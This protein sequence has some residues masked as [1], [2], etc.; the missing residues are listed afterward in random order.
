MA[1]ACA[2]HSIFA[3]DLAAAEGQ[4]HRQPR[5]VHAI[6]RAPQA[7]AHRDDA[8]A[9][10]A[11]EQQSAFT[12]HWT[13]VVV[14]DQK[15][16]MGIGPHRL[17]AAGNIRRRP[18]QRKETGGQIRAT[19]QIHQALVGRDQLGHVF[20]EH[21][22]RFQIIRALGVAL[23]QKPLLVR[24]PVMLEQTPPLGSRLGFRYRFEAQAHLRD[25]YRILKAPA[26]RLIG[27]FSCLTSSR[28]C[29]P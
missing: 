27:T 2:C 16:P 13:V 10:P 5:V 14:A 19:R 25:R 18:I 23:R 21:A 26:S 15:R 6:E 9:V 1:S 24:R 12:Q 28:G 17:R 8:P 4:R 7:V 11:T 3:D 22:P 29:E 20:S